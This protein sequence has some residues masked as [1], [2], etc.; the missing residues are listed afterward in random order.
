M[1]HVEIRP[2]TT[3]DCKEAAQIVQENPLWERYEYGA[4]EAFHSFTNALGN[5]DE[6]L[7]VATEPQGE[8]VGFA[9]VQ[10]SGGLGRAGYL[11]LIG[12][13]PTHH[14]QGIGEQLIQAA[15]DKCVGG[16][17]MLLV[18][19]FNERGQ[20]FYERMGYK[21]A[22]ELEAFVL[23][24]VNEILMWK[25]KEQEEKPDITGAF[26]TFSEE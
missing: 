26:S 4:D 19:D 8:I 12:V 9:W 24:D 14:G 5:Q 10:P 20:Q 15:E 1:Y 18:S 6:M 25:R 23:S 16:T 21:R 17:M 11:R 7:L 2:M 13:A 22:G 3:E